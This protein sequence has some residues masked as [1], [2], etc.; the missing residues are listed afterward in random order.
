MFSLLFFLVWI[1]SSVL[2]YLLVSHWYLIPVWI[3]SGLGTAFIIIILLLI[4]LMPIM[5]ITK[6]Q[7]K[8]KYVLLKS[9]SRFLNRFVLNL[10]V[11]AIGIENIPKD[12]K[13]TIYGNHKSKDDPFLIMAYMKR[14]MAF[15]PKISL[16]KI[17]VIANYMHYLGCLPIDRADNR[18]TAKTMISAIK[19]VESGL[20]M[21]IFPEGGILSREQNEMIGIKAGAYKI[22]MKAEA[23]FL[24][25]SI[26]N[27]HL[28]ASKKWW[29]RLKITVIYHPVVKYQDVK[30]LSTQELGEKMYEIIN[31]QIEKT[32]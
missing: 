24:P 11:K 23:D 9:V 14:A 29:Q 2:Y 7:W 1:G 28:I 18:R 3:I 6:P 13:L 27:N 10:S 22:G 21:L 26:I 20:A 5:K 4:I 17:P 25:V 32:E 12:G 19:N 15:T 16:Y 31:N 30:D 8:V